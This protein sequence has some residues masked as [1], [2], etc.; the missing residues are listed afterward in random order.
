MKR[1]NFVKGLL[2]SAS[3]LSAGAAISSDKLNKNKAPN[4]SNVMIMGIEDAKNHPY[5]NENDRVLISETGYL[6][7]YVNS[8]FLI[9]DQP[10]TEIKFDDEINIL[11]NSGGMLRFCD[12]EKA[13]TKSTENISRVAGKVKDRNS[14][15]SIDCFGDS[16]TFGQALEKSEGAINKTG[17]ATNFG[18][19]STHQ[20]WQ[21]EKNYPL[22]MESVLKSFFNQ[23][24][25]VN[26]YGYSG[27]RAWT[28]YLRHR[29]RGNSDLAIIM[30]GI[31]DCVYASYNGTDPKSISTSAID[32]VE[33]YSRSIRRFVLKQII[34]GKACIIIGNSPFASLV[35]YDGTDLS[36][37]KLARAYNASCRAVADELG[38]IY[39]DTISEFF[40]QY[41]YKEITQEFT[42]L[43]EN[44]ISILA[45]KLVSAILSVE[46]VTKVSH[47]SIV[48]L[49]PST[50]PII[51]K[52]NVV[53]LPNKTSKTP[54]G[55]TDNQKT[56]INV[57]ENG[58]LI[59]FYTEC[60]DLVLF[61]NGQCS[62]PGAEFLISLDGSSVQSDY[63]YQR[64]SV[65][66]RPASMKLISKSTLFNRENCLISD[67]HSACLTISSPGWHYLEIRKKSGSGYVLIDSLFF[68]SLGNVLQS[69]VFGCTANITYTTSSAS[70]VLNISSVDNIDDGIFSFSFDS[71]MQNANYSVNVDA[72][73]EHHANMSRVYDK[74]LS[75]FKVSF[76][77]AASSKQ[78]MNFVFYNP[79][80]FSISVIGGK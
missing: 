12:Y 60:P 80:S 66:G 55:T 31:N 29:E 25:H 33:E 53:A 28:G 34:K 11:I 38:C 47:G 5:F 77:Q 71:D 19:G 63:Q 37:V 41:G 78:S 73:S 32:S 13:R 8:N 3:L 23:E 39:I 40:S 7:E 36:S 57:T 70:Q 15:I 4:I 61:V 54:I 1:R 26:N 27:D 44:G 49:N 48:V 72:L 56:T 10:L 24:I 45:N 14:S 9:N 17:S 43:N 22:M 62:K 79:K 65:N 64:K 2:G 21:F 6:Y 68:E 20:H 76:M 52:E 30:Y 67:Q 46:K 42:H 69:D 74:T 50:F 51:S 18:D 75:G 16:I 58:V 35:G 59:P